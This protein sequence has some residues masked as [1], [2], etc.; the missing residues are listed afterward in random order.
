MEIFGIVKRNMINLGL[1]EAKHTHSR[2]FRIIALLVAFFMIVYGVCT[3]IWYFVSE[4]ETF[5]QHAEGILSINVFCCTFFKF[6]I[7]VRQ[8]AAILGFV[9]KIE[10]AIEKRKRSM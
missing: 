9:Q 10:L 7:I 6:V 3:T 1:M 2:F 5:E 4:A 8:H